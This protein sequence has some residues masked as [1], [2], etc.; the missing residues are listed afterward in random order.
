MTPQLVC[1]NRRLLLFVCISLISK[2]AISQVQISKGDLKLNFGAV[3]SSYYNKRW[4]DEDASNQSQNKDRFKLRDARIYLEGQLGK[5]Y[6]LNLQ[7]DFS[8]IGNSIPDPENPTL[9][10]ANIS[11]KASRNFKLTLGYGKLPFSRASLSPFIKSPYW[12][13]AEFFRGDVFSRRDVGLTL[14]QSLWKKHIKVH[15]GAYSGIGEVFF[16]GDNDP[17]GSLEYILRVEAAYPGEYSYQEIDENNSATPKFCAAAN[18]RY[19]ERNLEEGESF[20][21]GQTGPYGLKSINGKRLGYGFDGAFYWQ[22]F[23]MQAETELFKATPAMMNDP[24]LAGLPYAQTNGYLKF[25]GFMCQGNYHIQK[26]HTIVSLRYDLMD[27]NDLV[28]GKAE[29]LSAS[30]A[31]QLSGFNSMIK[32]QYFRILKEDPI[33]SQRYHDQFRI[34]WQLKL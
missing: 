30:L 17:S 32:A 7:I 33:D 27:L 9:F 22:G 11:Y 25:G 6:E 28:Q 4:I 20:I 5:K 29:R 19:T 14:E 2:S 1:S 13:R 8:S 15:A 34:G 31:Y 21:T 24:L 10:D 26:A 3:V 18:I 12:Q 16:Q 23:S